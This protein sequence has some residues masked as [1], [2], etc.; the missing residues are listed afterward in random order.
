M[1][2]KD[3][4]KT[5]KPLLSCEIFPP[6]SFDNMAQATMVARQTAMLRPA[7]IS[8]TY[9]NKNATADNTI[10]I[11][12]AVKDTGAVAIAHLTCV[13]NTHEQ[14]RTALEDLRYN[15]IENIMALRG[16]IPQDMPFP[17][18]GQYRHAIDLIR[19]INA[20]G[21]FCVGAAC[22]PEK[23]PESASIGQDIAFLKEKVDAGVDFLVTQMFFDNSV[24][25]NYL[26]RLMRAGL[27][28]PVFAGIMPLCNAKQID[29]AAKLSNC[30]LPTRFRM[31]VDR[32]GGNPDAMRQA[33]IAYATEQ[34]IDLISNGVEHIHLYTMNKP[35][36]AK[37]IID[38]LSCTLQ[39]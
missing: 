17:M 6:K 21:G 33:G 4:L 35:D 3:L 1:T 27:R 2:I 10:R 31:M 38:N 16:D 37:Q 9:T 12:R 8:V 23:H 7:F 24:L 32:F 19:E 20:F 26:Y 18:P 13:T 36:I 5:N 11:A 14:V 15:G 22:Y 25:Y 39:G 34:I 28:V 29:N 30:S